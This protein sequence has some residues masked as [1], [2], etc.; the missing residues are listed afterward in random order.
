MKVHLNRNLFR[1]PGVGEMREK[2]V[3]ILEDYYHRSVSLKKQLIDIHQRKR[4]DLM[5]DV[6]VY[7]MAQAMTKNFKHEMSNW[8]I[9]V[10]VFC[11]R[12]QDEDAVNIAKY[13]E[14]IEQTLTEIEAVSKGELKIKRPD[15]E[16]S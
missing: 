2:L 13:I 15:S 11:V 12:E 3:A 8:G 4:Q 16:A 6:G 1:R 14:Y 10:F 5:D 9:S 7:A